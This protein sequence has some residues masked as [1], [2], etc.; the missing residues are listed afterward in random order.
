MQGGHVHQVGTP[1]QVYAQPATLFVASFVGAMNVVADLPSVPAGCWRS[2]RDR[3][4]CK[5]SAASTA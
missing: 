5:R 1:W 2:A 3:G 4:P